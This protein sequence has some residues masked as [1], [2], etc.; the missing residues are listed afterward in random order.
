MPNPHAIFHRPTPE[1]LELTYRRRELAELRAALA[2]RESRLATLRNQ[3]NAFEGRYIRQV[4][5]LYIQ[6]DEWHDRLAELKNP[7]AA[8]TFIPSTNVSS[9]PESSQSHREDAVERPASGPGN[10]ISSAASYLK[11]LFREVAKR[12]H[13]DHARDHH[14]E[15]HRTQLMA[16][17]NDAFL[18]EDA[19]LLHRMLHSH[20]LPI[21]ATDARTELAR[22]LSLI[23]HLQRDV[24]A[25]HSEM[26]ALA[27]CEM[28]DL[29]RRT[30]AAAAQGSDLL[31]ELAARVK[32]QI[33]IAMSR[34]ERE[35]ARRRSK[36]PAADPAS[37][38][39]AET[40]N[41]P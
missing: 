10:D 25:L 27:Q 7:S 34:Y 1:D 16:Q 23:R 18:R 3:L 8:S 29:Q 15:Q 40:P 26:E 13:P 20:D 33:G 24:I 2:E 22:T 12:I 9:R 38:L 11:A 31:A 5:V 28:A 14:D 30:V 19:A 41:T 21:Q 37:L 36:Q 39:S 4:G 6:L 32:G 35:L 17:A